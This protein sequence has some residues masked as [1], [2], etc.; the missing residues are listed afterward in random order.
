MLTADRDNL[1][2]IWNSIVF[3]P[4]DIW[5]NNFF[6]QYTPLSLR[7]TLIATF[8]ALAGQRCEYILLIVYCVWRKNCLFWGL[9]LRL[10]WICDNFEIWLDFLYKALLL[11]L[12]F[13]MIRFKSW[14]RLI[15]NI[16]TYICFKWWSQAFLLI[17]I[18]IVMSCSYLLK[19]QFI[20]NILK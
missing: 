2:L 13:I 12:K 9:S 17:L 3:K 14:A 4:N 1:K 11:Q 10:C 15:W 19:S 8:C 6:C 5:P 18:I 16:K 7:M 20:F